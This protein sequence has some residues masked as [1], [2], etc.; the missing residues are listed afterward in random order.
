MIEY[1]NGG[2]DGGGGK[3]SSTERQDLIIVPHI[4]SQVE[5]GGRAMDLRA[6][7]LS[8]KCRVHLQISPE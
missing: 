5:G 1:H 4:T 7:V 3:N 6:I 8:F 2:G